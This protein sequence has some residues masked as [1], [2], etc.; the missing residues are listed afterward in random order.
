MWEE[1]ELWIELSWRIDPD[2]S[3]GIRQFFESRE[4]PGERLSV[5][6]YYGWMFEHSVP[7]LPRGRRGR[8]P[9]TPRVHAPPRRL[10]GGQGRRP[11]ARDRRRPGRAGRSVGRRARPCLRAHRPASEGRTS[12]PS[13]SPKVTVTAAARS[14]SLVD[15][16]VRRGFPD[17]L[18]SPRVLLADPGRLGLARAGDPDLRP[19]PRAPPAPGRRAGPAD[20]HVPAPDADP[21]AQRQL[22]VARRAGSHEPAVDPPVPRGHRGRRDGRPRPRRDRPRLLRRARRG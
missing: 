13:P 15:G 8:R 19:E 14:A 3:L 16:V 9:D 6:E 11:A 7:G 1:N 5:D 22:E 10:R 18:R 12:L 21:H 4:R 20:L 17:A 2:G